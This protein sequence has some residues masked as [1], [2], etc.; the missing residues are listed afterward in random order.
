MVS[1]STVPQVVTPELAGTPEL[2][3]GTGAPLGETLLPPIGQ[4]VGWA[5]THIGEVEAAQE[6][7]DAGP[8]PSAEAAGA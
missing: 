6:A 5:D 1:V 2:V 7:Y 4:L 8:C 3:P